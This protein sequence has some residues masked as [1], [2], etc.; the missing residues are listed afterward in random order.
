VFKARRL[1]SHSTLRSRVMR[2][3]KSTNTCRPKRRSVRG[4]RKVDVRLPGKGNS[5]SHGAR[6]VY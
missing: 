5:N 6:P 3:E 4:P 1:V 2:K